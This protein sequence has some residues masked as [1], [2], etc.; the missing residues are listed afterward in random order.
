MATDAPLL[1]PASNGTLRLSELVPHV[2]DFTGTFDV[3]IGTGPGQKRFT[4]HH[5]I[6]TKRSPFFRAARSQ[7][8][9][10]D[11]SKPVELPEHDPEVFSLY[12][13]CVYRNR[14]DAPSAANQI[15][16]IDE[17][18]QEVVEVYFEALIKLYVLAD[19]LEDTTTA[20][21]AMDSIISISVARKAF[22]DAQAIDLAYAAPID[23][24]ILSRLIR[25]L[26]LR[27][28]KGFWKCWAE[29]RELLRAGRQVLKPS[30]KHEPA[31]TY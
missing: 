28:Q 1:M 25:E 23:D 7:R 11:P 19:Q 21:L 10:K 13:A 26:Y 24:Y 18:T 15:I 2:F 16:K 5:S 22:P 20:E 6:I 8:W 4:V 14:I 29:R 3:L 31:T 9:V 30:S 27:Y 17:A 12:L